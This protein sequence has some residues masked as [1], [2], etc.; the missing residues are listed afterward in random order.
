[1]FCQFLVG[2]VDV[3]VAGLIN[4]DLQ[5]SMGIITQCLFLL[6]VVG[7]A[8]AGG[9]VSAISQAEGANLPRRADR[10]AGLIFRMGGLLCLMILLPALLFSG[11]LLQLLQVPEAIFPMTKRLWNLYIFILPANYL[12]IVTIAVFRAHKDV[13]IPLISGIFVCLINAFLNYGLGLGYFGLPSMGG[14]GL[15]WAS[16]TSVSAGAILNLVVLIRKGFISRSSFGGRRWEK[17]ALPYILKVA[18]PAGGMSV[19]WQLG[20]L[21]LYTITATLPVGQV[22]A[23]AGLTAGMRIEAALFMPAMAFNLTGSVL[24]G[25]C[26]GAGDKAEAKRVALRVIG[27][28]ALVMTVLGA[29][30]YP[31][32]SSIV[33]LIAVDPAI[34]AVA[35]S[36]MDYNIPAIPFTVTSMIMGGIMTGA[37]S[38]VYTLIIYSAA[39][40]LVRLPLA[41]YMGHQVWKNATG[42]FVAMLVSQAAQAASAMYVLLRLDWYRFASTAN[43]M[44]RKKI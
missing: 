39:T 44:K 15:I 18:L 25:N 14:E 2:F 36:Y 28:G 40:W 16:I 27:A 1:M 42:I 10:Y 12:T 7:M 20:Y 29:A 11:S 4:P 6:M 24:V 31:F 32:M 38:T 17:K 8:A 23:V 3:K 35:M 41:W 22:A 34:H 5:A 30:I 37:G 43:R 9:A 33:S 26:L 13:L 21:M 19:L